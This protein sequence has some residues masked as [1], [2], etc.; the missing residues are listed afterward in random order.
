MLSLSQNFNLILT[1]YFVYGTV[2][3]TDFSVKKNVS[4]L[5]DVTTTMLDFFVAKDRVKIRSNL[6]ER[7]TLCRYDVDLFLLRKYIYAWFYASPF[8]PCAMFSI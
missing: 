4:L 1:L 8:F 5:T 2:K 7:L 3:K 6:C